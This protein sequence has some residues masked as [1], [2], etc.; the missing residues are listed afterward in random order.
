MVCSDGLNAELT[1]EHILRIL[2]TVGHP[3][4]AVDALIQAAL[5]SGGRDNV[6]VIVVDAKN[7]LNDAGAATTAPRRDPSAEDEVTLP[8][9]QAVQ[10]TTQPLPQQEDNAGQAQAAGQQTRPGTN[11]CRAGSRRRHGGPAMTGT[12]YIPGTWLGIVRSHTAVILG[13]DTPPA[14]ADSV[15]NLIAGKTEVYEVLQAITGSAGGNLSRIPP[16]AIL[17]FTGP[18]RVFLRGGLELSVE[19]PDGTRGAERPRRHHLERTQFRRSRSLHPDDPG[20]RRNRTARA[21]AGGGHGAA[22]GHPTWALMPGR[23][24]WKLQV[25]L[26]FRTV[27]ASPPPVLPALPCRQSRRQLMP[28]IRSR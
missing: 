23:A 7:V 27:G 8:R 25:P 20:R 4:D 5:R 3:Q 19:T 28:S 16:F 11:G 21:P 13:P 17:D 12:S 22:A 14:L 24:R 10:A 2:S 6:T 26:P 9:G 18:L 15:W 1:D